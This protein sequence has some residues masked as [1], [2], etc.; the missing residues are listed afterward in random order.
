MSTC[1]P[2]LA[3]VRDRTVTVAIARGCL[4]GG[5]PWGS[6]VSLALSAPGSIS[7]FHG[8]AVQADRDPLSDQEL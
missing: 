3:C 8:Y 1:V 5:C 7:S 2:V 6:Q 4:E